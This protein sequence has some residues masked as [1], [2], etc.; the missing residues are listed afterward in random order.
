MRITTGE[1]NDILERL[2]NKCSSGWDRILNKLL[3]KT[4]PIFRRTLA[5]LLNH[6]YNFGHTPRSWRFALVSPLPKAGK[7]SKNVKCYRPISLLSNLAKVWERCL[8]L[9]LDRFYEDKRLI[10]SS[11]YGFCKGLGTSHA[12]TVAGSKI[13]K[14]LNRKKTALVVLLDV[15]KAYDTVNIAKLMEKLTE[16]GLPH[17]LITWKI[18]FLRC[19][20]AA[21][22]RAS[23][24]RLWVYRKGRRWLPGAIQSCSLN[25]T[26]CG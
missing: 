10:P 1:I 16:W 23:T 4:G 2:N 19:G 7:P 6:L 18:G 11:Q 9:R 14:T 15:E 24:M 17:N 21:K 5:I 26:V 8:L 12:L 25:C 22:L 3:K 20:C 13:A